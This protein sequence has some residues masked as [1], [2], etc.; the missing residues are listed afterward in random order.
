MSERWSLISLCL[1]RKV[2]GEL[3]LSDTRSNILTSRIIYGVNQ[4]IDG[5]ED[6]EELWNEDTEDEDETYLRDELQYLG[7]SGKPLESD[8][9]DDLLEVPSEENQQLT[10]EEYKEVFGI[11]QED[12]HECDL[13]LI[14]I[15]QLKLQVGYEALVFKAYLRFFAGHRPTQSGK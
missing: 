8:T 4:Y 14:R 13:T 2:D 12:E 9:N 3:E 6:G 1:I 7:D 10:D 5:E 15:K 11:T